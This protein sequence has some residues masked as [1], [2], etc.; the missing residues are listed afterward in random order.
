MV[1]STQIVV[2]KFW[3]DLPNFKNREADVWAGLMEVD[4]SLGIKIIEPKQL[5]LL[6][7]I[8]FNEKMDGLLQFCTNYRKP[9]AV[10]FK[11]VYQILRMS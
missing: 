1:Q 4:K 10:I 11:D 6:A 7:L 8:V 5:K 3:T 2:R 9:N